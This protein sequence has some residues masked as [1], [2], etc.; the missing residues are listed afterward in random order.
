MTSKKIQ[1]SSQLAIEISWTI[2]STHKSEILLWIV[3]VKTPSFS[4]AK[5]NV[6]SFGMFYHLLNFY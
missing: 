3:F 5:E 4:C 6:Q 2:Y 1:N